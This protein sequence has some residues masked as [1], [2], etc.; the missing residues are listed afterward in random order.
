MDLILLGGLSGAGK[1]GAL[2]ML[3]DIG[4]HI[5]DNL[6]LPL[7]APTVAAILGDGKKRYSR[8]AIGIDPYSTPEEFEELAALIESW[9]GKPHG[10]T[11]LYLFCEPGTLIKRYR[12]TRRRHPLTSGDTD[13]AAAIKLES[14]IL[15]PLAQLADASIDTTHTNIHQLREIVRERVAE[16][17]EHP[18]RLQI[19]SFG[20]RLGLAQEADLIFDMRCLPNPYWDP[21]LREMTG[22][23]QPIM[24]YLEGH[25]TVTRMLNNISSFMKDWLPSYAASNRSYLTIA[26]GCT[27]GRHRSVYMAEQLAA[28]LAQSGW[29]ITVRHRDLDV[30]AREIRPAPADG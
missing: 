27:G 18:M 15:E 6:P 17:P 11:V 8:L 23:D 1:T 21:S 28:Q 26:L 24:E 19:E 5:V 20:Y 7:I 12:A 2:D 3:E 14:R 25:N 13:L 22:L 16:T 9:R 10:C 30:P 4:Y 29:R